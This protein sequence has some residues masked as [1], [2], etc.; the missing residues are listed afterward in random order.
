MLPPLEPNSANELHM[1]VVEFENRGGMTCRL[2]GPWVELLPQSGADS[3]TNGFFSDQEKTVSERKFAEGQNQVGP[4]ETAHMLV[5][6]YSVASLMSGGCVNRDSLTLSLGMNQPPF[7][8]VDHLWMRVC[9]RAYVSSYRTGHYSGEAVP[10]EWLKRLGGASPADFAP[11]PIAAPRKP[12]EALIATGPRYSPIMLH[13]FFGLFVELPRA[14]V[15]CP[16][17]VLR[18]READGATKAYINHCKSINAPENEQPHMERTRWINWPRIELHP[19]RTGI[20]EYEVFSRIVEDE[21]PLYAEAKA[22]VVVR[23]PKALAPP[24]IDSPFPDCRAAQLKA[25]RATVIDGG[26]WHDAHVYEVTNIS[27]ETCQ[28]GGVPHLS[29]THPPGQ[30]FTYLPT[31]CPNC[32]DPLFEPRSSGWIDVRPGE[33]A[34]FLVGATRFN[35]ETG[36]WRQICPVENQVVLM[37]RPENESISLPFGAGTCAALTVSAWRAGKF[38]GDPKSVAYEKSEANRPESPVPPNCAKA[39]FSKLGRPMMLGV[40]FGLSVGPEK[41]IYGK[42]VMLHLWIDNQANQEV[43]VMTCMT[44]DLFWAEAFDLYDAYGHRLVKK[45]EQENG[46]QKTTSLDVRGPNQVCSGS[47]MCNRNFGIPIPAHTCTNGSAYELPYDFNRDLL[48]A[49]DLPPGTYYVVPRTSK[50]DES[51]CRELVP[52]LDPVLLR[53]QLKIVIEQD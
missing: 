8:L 21:K 31:A 16:F 7:L 2:Q 17:V 1:L 43:S 32:E 4:G 47:W 14:D 42:P 41:I 26:K 37:L 33:A 27:G 44:L 5:A 29:F 15:N 49:Y 13:D 28:L 20:V 50:M 30:S 36:R 46:K 23:N 18:K 52:R 12:Q 22:D 25:A 11:L 45:S 38:D 40:Q 10:D 9:D 3:F 39:D 19:E 51:G 53:N 6:W 48:A 34:H 24:S 35:T